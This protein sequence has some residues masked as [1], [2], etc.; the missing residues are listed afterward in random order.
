[1]PSKAIGLK[2]QLGGLA[3]MRGLETKKAARR[4]PFVG[5]GKRA[6]YSAAFAAVPLRA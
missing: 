4:L 1:M 2:T 6:D 5:A 3:A